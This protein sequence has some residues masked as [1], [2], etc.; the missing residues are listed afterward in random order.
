MK[1]NKK[2]R[3]YP[4]NLLQGPTKTV[5]DNKIPDKNETE[6]NQDSYILIRYVI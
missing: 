5:S 2:Q 1:T 6:Q 4:D 3:V